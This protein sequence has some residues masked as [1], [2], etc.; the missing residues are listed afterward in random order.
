MT[1]VDSN[2]GAARQQPHSESPSPAPSPAARSQAAPTPATAAPAAAAAD[3]TA[4]SA[5]TP[6]PLSSDPRKWGRVDDNGV[7]WVKTTAGEREVGSW[8]A[9]DAEEALAHFGRR[10][11]DLATEVAVLEARLESHPGEA[12]KTRS[13][14]QALVET[15]PGANVVGDLD[16]LE[17]RLRAIIERSVQV[18]DQA[19]RDKS[20][21]RAKAIARKE[22]LAGEAEQIGESSTQ[23][24]ASGDRLKEILEE[25]KT[26]R[27][28]DRK[29]DDA[30]WKRFSKARESFNRRRGS[31]FAELDRH[32]AAAKKAKE[33]LV[34]RAEAMQANTDWNDTARA[35]R[36]LMDEWK[37][38]G[39]ATREADDALWARFK[40]A[41]DTFFDARH[42][43]ASERDAAFETNAK[44]KESLL[45]EYGPKINPEQDLEGARRVLRELQDKWDAAGKVP[46]NRISEFENKIRE[47]EKK[48]DKAQQSEWRRTD[49]EAKARASQFWTR[50]EQF[51]AQAARAE[52]AGKKK[53]ADKARAQAAQWREWAEAAEQAVEDR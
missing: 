46:R 25:W 6:H 3:S 34:E 8:Q 43:A 37:A 49:P 24:K 48:V 45:A 26:I 5:V 1:D 40:K 35:F 28:I 44:V 42:A 13:S 29:T 36:A 52:A 15:V 21:A 7:V 16:A 17:T 30:L 51:E 50:V 18:E 23:W 53:D 47:L 20:A 11:D 38:A 2:A 27:G 32:R 39:R 22:E 10:F 41:Q 19:R 31:H 9:G 33:A 12:R 4:P 14:A